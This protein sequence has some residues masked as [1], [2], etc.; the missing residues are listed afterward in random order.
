M[1]ASRAFAAPTNG[2]D[3]SPHPPPGLPSTL[4]ALAADIKLNH[5]VFAL[6]FAVLGAFMARPAAESW[7][8]FAGQM[9]LVV[10]CMVSA[11]TFA[12]LANRILD[13][14]IDAENPRTQG[15]ALP[16]GRA[17]LRAAWTALAIA[18]LAFVAACGLFAVLYGNGWPL[19][20]A[21]PVLAWIGAYPLLKRF[22]WLCH[23]YLGSSL[24]ISPLAA[25]LAV[26]PGALAGGAAQPALWLMSL[27]VL[28]W[29]AGFDI[30]Y[31]LQDVAVDLKQGLHSMPS[32][33]GIRPALWISRSLHAV[34]VACLIG[35]VAIDARFSA[36]FAAGVAMVIALLIV[37]HVVTARG[38]TGRIQLA[39]FTLNGIISCLLGGLGIASVLIAHAPT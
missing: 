39:F 2:L 9:A 28:C 21:V 33:L 4:R 14:S 31:A 16:S 37:E 38:G 26:E 10:A 35:V 29:V 24:A 1:D 7:T 15:R 22:T 19:A 13:R 32:R 17:P 8:G 20:L 18:A 11:R 6:P 27:N 36:L 5:S 23:L 12:M 30:I 25:A 34:S 3:R